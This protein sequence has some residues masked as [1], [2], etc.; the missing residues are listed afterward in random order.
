MFLIDRYGVLCQYTYASPET[1]TEY[2]IKKEDKNT[3][4]KQTSSKKDDTNVNT[5]TGDE[6]YPTKRGKNWGG[7]ARETLTKVVAAFTEA[8]KVT[9]ELWAEAQTLVSQFPTGRGAQA[10]PVA[11]RLAMVESQINALFPQ[12]YGVKDGKSVILN[13]EAADQIEALF[14]RK[15]RLKAEQKKQAELKQAAKSA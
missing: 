7:M 1:G 6:K 3:M 12:A 13:Q 4:S 5:A 2:K 10:L 15:S 9:P 14:V 8:G 11:E